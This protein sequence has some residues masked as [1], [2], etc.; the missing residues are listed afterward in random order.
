MT[1]GS[2]LSFS[3]SNHHL[4][5]VRHQAASVVFGQVDA[6]PEDQRSFSG[7]DDTCSNHSF[8]FDFS[9]YFEYQLQTGVVI[10]FD[11]SGHPV[12]SSAVNAPIA[13]VWELK[14]GQLKEKSLFETTTAPPN[15]Y[16]EEDSGKNKSIISLCSHQTL[17]F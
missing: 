16:S 5:H 11:P 9:G 2:F 8:V 10:A 13:A 6:D 15:Y 4:F 7:N 1:D 3:V 12:W 17:L 14:N